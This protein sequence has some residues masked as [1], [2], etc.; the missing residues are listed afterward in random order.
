MPVCLNGQQLVNYG[1][2]SRVGDGKVLLGGATGLP[3]APNTQPYVA[4]V[5]PV[6][7]RC[8]YLAITAEEFEK[9]N[10]TVEASQ[11][12]NAW[13]ELGNM[14][15][16]DAQVISAYIAVVWAIAWGFRVLRSAVVDY[17]ES[18]QNE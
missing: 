14:S 12:S 4:V 5:G 7:G 3:T 13:E 17:Y 15:I 11:G 2:S 10:A 1:N 16:K 18:S 8:D 9:F 6:A